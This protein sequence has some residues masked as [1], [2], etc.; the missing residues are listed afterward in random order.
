MWLTWQSSYTEC[1]RPWVLSLVLHILSMV[2]YTCNPNTKHIEPSGSEVKLHNE[3][4]AN[5]SYAR[6]LVL[7]CQNNYK[8]SN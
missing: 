3:F 1:M 8:H 7:S 4:Q 5:L 2:A 6:C